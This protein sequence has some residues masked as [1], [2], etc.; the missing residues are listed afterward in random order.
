MSIQNSRC[1]EDELRTGVRI[2]FVEVPDERHEENDRNWNGG[3][4]KDPN[5]CLVELCSA[6]HW[7]K[8]R[9][10]Q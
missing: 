3:Q 7:I 8:G 4:A 5:N 2:G 9:S 1:Y 6:N 10:H